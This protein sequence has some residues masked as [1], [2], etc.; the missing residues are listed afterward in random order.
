[1]R[2][3]DTR[4]EL[5]PVQGIHLA[6]L[7]EQRAD[8]AL[9]A[10]KRIRT[11]RRLLSAT[12][13]TMERSG[14]E[15]LTIDAVVKEAGVA[16]GTFYLYFSDKSDA[17]IA[18]MRVFVAMMR[19]FRPRG[20]RALSAAESIYRTNLFYILSYSTNSRLLAGRESLMRDRPELIQTRDTINRRWTQT[21]LQDLCRR[22]GA[23]HALTTNPQARLAVRAVIAM[24][25][26]FLREIYVYKSPSLVDLAQTPDKVAEALS[27]VWHRAI[28]GCD[29]KQWRAIQGLPPATPEGRAQQDSA[30]DEAPL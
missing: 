12:A 15:G 7:L 25:D 27:Q 19:I 16:R 26:E 10:P 11:R 13:S 28:F 22:T 17:A 18:V 23:P 20:S 21:V 9:N 24:A 29:A 4:A 14:Y 30:E 8:A 6:T 5:P 3:H 1:M 2:K